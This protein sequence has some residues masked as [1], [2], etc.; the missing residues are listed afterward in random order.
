MTCFQRAQRK[1][2]RLG[3]SASRS[4]VCFSFMLL[5]LLAVASVQPA[6]AQTTVTAYKSQVGVT[7]DGT[8][9]Q[10]E[11][12][13][14]ASMTDPTSTLTVAFK[15]NGTGLLFLMSWPEAS[16]CDT[17]Y[18]GI[19]LGGLN[20]TGHMGGPGTAVII[21]LLSPSYN[22]S[23]DEAI[24]TGEQTPI[25]VEEFNYR[26]QSVCALGYSGTVYTAECYRPFKLTNAAPSNFNITVGTTLELGLAV[27]D[28][29]APGT[30][31]ATDMST[32]LLTISSQTY[33]ANSTSTVTTIGTPAAS[34]GE[35]SIYYY[36][37]ELAVAVVG[38]SLLVL[39]VVRKFGRG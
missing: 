13:D 25:P 22:K 14:T 36:S 15:Q 31:S 30:H 37:A 7:L 12:N 32:Y 4:L 17:C 29:S 19:E 2:G 16:Q 33:V 9:Q 34:D 21:I 23:V 10:G 26:T 24:G 3:N 39:L 20:N 6:H 1:P 38:F 11:W 5:F 35:P 27:G 8:V 18:A 28:F